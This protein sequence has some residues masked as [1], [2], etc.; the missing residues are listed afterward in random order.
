MS[1]VYH[2]SFSDQERLNYGLKLLHIQWEQFDQSHVDNLVSSIEGVS[3]NGLKVTLIPQS[4]VCRSTCNLARRSSY[5]VWHKGGARD[6]R[7]KKNGASAGYVWFLVNNWKQI[8]KHDNVIG[9][10]WLN[11]ISSKT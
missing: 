7:S 10:E 11:C 5:T 6:G 3:D 9:I 4:T 2:Q 1:E 8:C